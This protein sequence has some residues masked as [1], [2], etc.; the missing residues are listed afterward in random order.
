MVGAIKA[1]VPNPDQYINVDDVSSDIKKRAVRGGAYTALSQAGMFV[2]RFGSTAVMARILVPA[3]YGLIA[4]TAV[5]TGFV[6]MFKD[7]GLTMATIQKQNVTHRQ[8]STLFW[9]NVA[10]GCLIA[11]ALIALAPAV[12]AFYKEPKLVGITRALALG[13]V[14]GGFTLQ[15]LALL[16]RRLR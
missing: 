3:D 8:V 6:G 13:F 7:A 10:L 12:A 4:M 1:P 9:I 2:I 11:A 5:V 15:H 16:R 14:F